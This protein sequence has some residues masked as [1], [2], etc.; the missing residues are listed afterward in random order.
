[1][2]RLLTLALLFM[3]LMTLRAECDYVALYDESGKSIFQT[4]SY[5]VSYGVP[6]DRLDFQLYL[7]GSVS[8]TLSVTDD[9]GNELL[10]LPSLYSLSN[11]F[12]GKWLTYE[13]LE[14]D[15]RAR[16]ITFTF[17]GGSTL[18]KTVNHIRLSQAI[19]V[20]TDSTD[21]RFDDTEIGYAT[22]RTVNIMHSAADG[23]IRITSTNPALFTPNISVIND[24]GDCR[25]GMEQMTVT[26]SPTA[27]GPCSGQISISDGSHTAVI[28]MSAEAV[29]HPQ[30]I[31]WTDARTIS[32]GHTVAPAATVES[33]LPLRF[34]SSD[35]TVITVSGDT[36]IA[37][38]PGTATIIA[39]QD[40]NDAYAPAADSV[41][42]TATEL[43]VQT[44]S[45]TQD[46][47]HIAHDSAYVLLTAASSSGLPVVYSTSDEQVCRISGDT[48]FILSAGS[49]FI[50]ASVAATDTLAEARL[51]KPVSIY[52]VGL[53]CGSTALYDESGKSI[54][55]NGS[56][57]VAYDVPAAQLAF[58]L[59]LPGSVAGTLT[60]TDNLGNQLL[61]LPSL[62]SL[63]ST[64]T[65]KWLTYDG[66]PVDQRAR[67]ITFTFG[68]GSTLSKV[69]NH[70]H[71][72][73]AS[74]LST[75]SA[76]L[77]IET[78][79]MSGVSGMFS[80][81]Y[82]DIAG[83]MHI[84]NRNPNLEIMGDRYVDIPCGTYGTHTFRYNFISPVAG[85]Q[86]DT[87]VVGNGVVDLV[88]PVD[89]R[90][91]GGLVQ[92]IDWPQDLSALQID[93]TLRL[94]ATASS[95][96]P[97]QF[98]S[99][100]S[101]VA[102]I[103]GDT[104]L[105]FL[106][107]GTAT[108]TALQPGSNEYKEAQPFEQAVSVDRRTPSIIFAPT[109]QHLGLGERLI[110]SG[111]ENGEAD[112]NGTFAWLDP[113]TILSLGT[114]DMPAVFMPDNM[115]YYTTVDLML[116]VT[117]DSLPPVRVSILTYPTASD[118]HY[119]QS[120]SESQLTGGS[121]SAAGRF[122]WADEGLT[123]DAGY[124]EFDV[125]FVADSAELGRAQIS[126]GVNVAQAPQTIVWEQD[127][128]SVRVGDTLLL[129]ARSSMMFDIIY[130]VGDS[131][132]VSIRQDT[133]IALAPGRTSLTA[134]QPGNV[135]FM[136][137]E[138]ITVYL[139]VY[140]PVSHTA[141][142]GVHAD[143]RLTY[144]PDARRVSI[145]AADFRQAAVYTADGRLV[146]TSDTPVFSLP[147]A[148][149]G[150]CLVRVMTAGGVSTHKLNI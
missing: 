110:M 111:F 19:Y 127:F 85:P 76:S 121:A 122:V 123:P 89:I 90:V 130:Q 57:T 37:L 47:M 33:E 27:A 129:T 112:V 73:Q 125:I 114:H 107:P 46:L 74:Y 9:L 70:I 8:G 53:E 142:A 48:L 55:Q 25:A 10:Y 116:S 81:Q 134:T 15:T 45:W 103:D 66:I 68:G 80:V 82:S 16:Q 147:D 35:S 17:G 119:G 28:N 29:R 93:D 2:K 98:V 91:G 105:Y 21:I 41:I 26:F 64:F 78:A 79:A 50:T 86:Q 34:I 5:T 72:T 115:V 150:L 32:T 39:L 96:L 136:A 126:V 84:T 87:I 30:P 133:L 22:T 117:V 31:L 20:R 62:Y 71:L 77:L 101:T 23:P 38:T 118:L 124:H 141:L 95:G 139:E 100:D 36:L 3:T 67:Q 109:A 132:I 131:S 108:I 104:L 138:G 120:L 40:G 145:R 51:S 88:I 69:V 1:M 24:A 12:T 4:G 56:Y 83:P 75:D 54:F 144:Q 137:A 61:Y 59:Y 113:D 42:F 63:S 6:A 143:I 94:A 135:N 99:S 18:S 146:I 60:V 92:V 149:Q 148:L 128:D 43:A 7:P 140:E 11:T 14:V 97:V 49:T 106:A 65:G 44:I 52:T 13:G 58:Q 102:Y